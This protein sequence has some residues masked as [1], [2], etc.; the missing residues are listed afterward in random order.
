MK[1]LNPYKKISWNLLLLS[2]ALLT[3]FNWKV[4]ENNLSHTLWSVHIF[5]KNSNFLYNYTYWMLWIHFWISI[6]NSRHGL[7]I[8]P[9]T[10]MMNNLFWKVT[11]YVTLSMG[12]MDIVHCLVF[13]TE[14]N[15][16]EIGC[17]CPQV[18]RWGGMYSV[19]SV[20]KNISNWV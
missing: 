11:V 20:R 13:Q 3:K 19:G 12:F 5:Y 7:L 10:W 15:I 18:K 8:I 4:P 6:F 17:Y 16:L 14:L 9:K 2:Q 1:C